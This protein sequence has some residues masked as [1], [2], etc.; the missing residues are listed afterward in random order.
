MI[1]FDRFGRKSGWDKKLPKGYRAKL[2]RIKRAEISPAGNRRTELY[3]HC[4][5][6]GSVFEYGLLGKKVY[7]DFMK[8][9]KA[10]T[11]DYLC[12]QRRILGLTNGNDV[13]G[14]AIDGRCLTPF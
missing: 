2:Y 14:V 6:K 3:M 5:N 1:A 13:I 10:P 12:Y 11:L 8:V 4:K 9:L 7:E